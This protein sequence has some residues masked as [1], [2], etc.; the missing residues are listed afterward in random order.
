MFAR[1]SFF[2]KP[3]CA[4]CYGQTPSPSRLTPPLAVP[5]EDLLL[6]CKLNDI[7]DFSWSQWQVLRSAP[8][9]CCCRINH[10]LSEDTDA[11][12]KLKQKQQCPWGVESGRS[13]CSLSSKKSRFLSGQMVCGT[14]LTWGNEAGVTSGNQVGCDLGITGPCGTQLLFAIALHPS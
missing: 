3:C 5:A 10:H 14:D 7:K 9:L 12:F 1:R 4:P 11:A 13:D 2:P 8:L 6:I